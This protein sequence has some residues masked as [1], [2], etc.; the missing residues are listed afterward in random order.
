MKIK[1][2]EYLTDE[3]L[4]ESMISDLWEHHAKLMTTLKKYHDI[5]GKI[6]SYTA[7]YEGIGILIDDVLDQM[8][9]TRN[10]INAYEDAYDIVKRGK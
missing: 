10:Y 3:T 8:E 1:K 4:L 2:L 7:D 6:S 9:N 5:R